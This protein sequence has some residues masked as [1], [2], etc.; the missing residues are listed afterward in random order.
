MAATITEL[1][2]TELAS[3]TGLYLNEYEEIVKPHRQFLI[4]DY[5]INHWLRRLKP[6]LA[7]IV[8][9]LQQACWRVDADTCTISQTQLGQ[10]IG[11]NRSTITRSLKN[12][13]RHWFIPTISYNQAAFNL[14]KKT[15]Q[16]LPAQYTV[17]LSSPLIPDHLTGFL[18]Y[19]KDVVPA[20]DPATITR[21]IQDLIDQ[22]SKQ[23]LKVLEGYA[24]Q[25]PLFSDPLPLTTVLETALD[26]K[27][28]RLP[29]SE[30]TRL[31]QQLATL[32]T[33]LTRGDTLCRQYF[34]LNWVP[35]LGPT[36]AWLIIALRSRCYYNKTTGELRDTYIWPKKEL[37][38]I[39]GQSTQNLRIRLLPHAYAGHFFQILE[40]NKHKL[41]IQVGMLEEPL[42]TESASVYWQR[43][44]KNANFC[45]IEADETQ[46]FAT[47]AQPEGKLLPHRSDQNAN[48]CHIEA[49]ETQTFATHG[50]KT[51]NLQDSN[52][53]SEQ[54]IQKTQDNIVGGDKSTKD[55][56][57]VGTQKHRLFEILCQLPSQGMRPDVAR[58]ILATIPE[59]ALIQWLHY[60]F[61]ERSV[62][63]PV[64]FL[65]A[66]ILHKEAA[67]PLPP[68]DGI[69]L[70][71]RYLREVAWGLRQPV[72]ETDH[73]S[74][75]GPSGQTGE[76]VLW[77][78][79][80]DQLQLQMTR[81]IFDK[82]LKHTR[83]VR[84]IDQEYT[85]GVDNEQAKAW[86]ANRLRPVIV[87]TLAH[88]VGQEVQ[89]NFVVLSDDKA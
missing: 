50:T 19:L 79:V 13:W 7:W 49:D 1:P 40:D 15:F 69:R 64:R 47:S 48:F 71:E 73:P 70:Q 38:G 11:I 45:H 24:G 56:I 30:T 66:S 86:L 52:Q 28:N 61:E 43:Q 31:K 17:Y 14:R 65:V 78:E 68:T 81:A 8:I 42:T 57:Q 27:L 75:G 9:A 58:Q 88:V 87:R 25:Q 2:P 5:F 84:V 77:Q 33:H 36:L 34:R 80:L 6:S 23:A 32:Q 83:I 67:A 55:H 37:A 4:S 21:A 35:K 63:D 89:V 16:P 74:A 3:I 44:A 82:W 26:I 85:I 72:T 76:M 51:L 12:P 29:P 60:V 46:T 39:L 53:D 62:I 22:P 10:E 18:G 54:N 59:T 20:K 41:T